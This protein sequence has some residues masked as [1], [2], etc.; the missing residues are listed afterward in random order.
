MTGKVE[1]IADPAK[2][3]ANCEKCA[4]ERKD[5]PVQGRTIVQGIRRSADE[6]GLFDGG[7]ILDPNNG[8]VYRVR[9][10]PEEGG[11]RL[12]VRGYI[13]PF[14]RTQVWLRVE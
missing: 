8:K 10:K 3:T 9:L 4:D 12:E 1:K 13:G 14:Y 6:P 5:K 11:K 7:R 2:A